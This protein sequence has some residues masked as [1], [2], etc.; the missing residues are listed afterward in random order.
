MTIRF[1]HL[2]KNTAEAYQTF[3]EALAYHS[4]ARLIKKAS[5]FFG[6]PVLLTDEHYKLLCMYPAEKIGEPIYDT[7]LDQRILPFKTIESY[8]KM[9]LKNE[10]VFY[11]PFYSDSG[12]VCECP[13]IF[14]EVYSGDHIYGHF[15]VMMFSE[16]L[17]DEDLECACILRKALAIT[18]SERSAAPDSSLGKYLTDLLSP[19][20]PDHLKAFAADTIQKT[21]SGNYALMVTPLGSNAG[22]RAFA[23]MRTVEISTRYYSAVSTLYHDRLVTLFG[24]VSSMQY[25]DRERHF[26]ELSAESLKPA[27]KSGLSRPFSGL[28]TLTDHFHEASLAASAGDSTLTLFSEAGFLPLFLA[29]DPDI[30]A[31]IFIHPVIFRIQKYDQENGTFYLQT[32]RAYSMN[33]HSKERTSAELHIHRNTLLYRINRIVELFDVPV[34]EPSTAL[35]LLNSFQI[36]DTF[37]KHGQIRTQKN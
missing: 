32:L 25:T 10:T 34:D 16:K 35:A 1:H 29:I 28:L 33:M 27:G 20:S 7:L 8:Q 21:I 2:K 37:K 15:A 30:D 22:A 4:P 17:Y 5:E 36:L 26:F 18:M 19:A 6:L 11:E 12:L 13:R 24:S 3:F 14:G 31:S 23:A 9:Y